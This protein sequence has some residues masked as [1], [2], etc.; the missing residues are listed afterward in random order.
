MPRLLSAVVLFTFIALPSL[1][2]DWSTNRGNAQRTGQID[3]LPGPSTPKVLWVHR[4]EDHFIAAP[5]AGPNAVYVSGLG[6]LNTSS[7]QALNTDPAAKARVVWSKT[8]PYLKLPVASAPA[9]S[10]GL[11]VF[12]DGMHQTDGGILHC[13]RT[14][15]GSP[16]WQLLLP[17][18]LVHLEGSPTIAHN[19]VY[20][21][22]GNA[23]VVCVELEKLK[24]AGQ[25]HDRATAQK[26]LDDEW[27]KLLAKY[28]ADKKKDPDFAFPP[29]DEALTKPEP[30]VVWQQGA[31]K[32]HV[33]AS[34]AVVGDAVLVASGYLDAEKTGE[35]ALFS[36][37]AA[38]GSERWKVP[39][40]HNPWAGATVSGDTVLVGCSNIR[41]DPKFVAQGQGEVIAISLAT[42]KVQWQKKVTGGVVSPI[43]AVDGLAIFT[44]TDGKLRAFDIGTSRLKWTYDGKTP[45]FAGPAVAAGTIYVADLAGIVHAVEL[46]SGRK[47]WTLDLAN[48]PAVRAPGMVYGSPIVQGGRLYLAT[49]NLDR[50]QK[51]TVVVCI[52]EK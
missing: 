23:G 35:R 18:E 13:L 32:W 10:N 11:L 45:F 6:A 26:K 48:D 30:I 8:A 31:K 16:L 19:R 22:G 49:C 37:N 1:A 51:G 36:L 34:V 9:V 24:L 39:L 28:E 7:F 46:S 17:G 50:D 14:D 20:M 40:Q 5:V 3:A 27:K 47:L 38:D 15:T 29:S 21:G 41:F 2:A 25:T 52:G 12:G 43:A 33:D 44:A 42:G 4:S